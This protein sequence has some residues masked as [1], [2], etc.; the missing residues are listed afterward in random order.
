VSEEDE[1]WRRE[2]GLEGGDGDADST[3]VKGGEK[4]GEG[5]KEGERWRVC[6]NYNQAQRLERRDKWKGRCMHRIGS[7]EA[8]RTKWRG[9]VRRSDARRSSL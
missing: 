1:G 8:R 9:E 5:K 6:G 7:K 2:E 3:F 4:G